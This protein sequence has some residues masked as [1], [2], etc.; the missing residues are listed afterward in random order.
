MPS[1]GQT[2]GPTLPGPAV[3]HVNAWRVASGVVQALFFLAY[4]LV[5]Y[6]A[7]TRLGTRSLGAAGSS[8]T[9]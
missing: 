9:S 2:S 8:T 6:Y 3:G 5:V 7:Y 4:P 1:D